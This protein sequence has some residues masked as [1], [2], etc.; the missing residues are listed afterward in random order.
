MATYCECGHILAEHVDDDRDSY[1][2]ECECNEFVEVSSKILEK[3][4]N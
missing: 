4:D 1:C 3:G 2:L